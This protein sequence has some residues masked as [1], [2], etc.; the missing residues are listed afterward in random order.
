MPETW[1]AL[2]E[3]PED[4]TVAVREMLDSVGARLHGCWWAV[5]GH[6]GYM[7]FEA[8]DNETATAALVRAVASGLTGPTDTVP[9]LDQAE[10]LTALGHAGHVPLRAIGEE[11]Q[12]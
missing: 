5:G 12:P 8:P 1:A 11:P 3:N 4:R 6:E 2:I 10:L 7:V 9:L